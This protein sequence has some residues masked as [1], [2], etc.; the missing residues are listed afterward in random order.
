MDGL[1]FQ[2]IYL[3]VFFYSKKLTIV[4]S[5]QSSS[6]WSRRRR[7]VFFFH[8]SIRYHNGSGGCSGGYL[9]SNS[10][11][12]IIRTQRSCRIHHKFLRGSIGRIGTPRVATHQKGLK[13]TSRLG[14]GKRDAPR[15]DGGTARPRSTCPDPS[16]GGSQIILI[17]GWIVNANPI[18]GQRIAVCEF[19][20]NTFP[21]IVARFTRCNSVHARS[22]RC[23]ID[24]SIFGWRRCR[25]DR[26]NL[27]W[28]RRRNVGW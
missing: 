28:R 10:I 15:V 24:D 14:K 19:Q 17:D 16:T 9:R 1:S 2:T 27:G 13:G 5:R 26:R 21:Q 22:G 11:S 6:E 25:S 3:L 12:I 7:C 23:I 20:N 8:I 4:V 18:I